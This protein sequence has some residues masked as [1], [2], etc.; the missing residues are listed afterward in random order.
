MKTNI[1]SKNGITLIA[2]VVTII[3]LLI[4]AGVSLNAIIGKNGIIENGEKS[5]FKGDVSSYK[6]ILNLKMLEE[7]MENENFVKNNVNAKTIA[8]IQKYIPNFN[9]KYENILEIFEGE[10]CA[11]SEAKG[12]ELSWLNELN[13]YNAPIAT[14]NIW[15]KIYQ[16][17]TGQ[18]IRKAFEQI[19]N[20]YYDESDFDFFYHLVDSNDRIPNFNDEVKIGETY[21][22]YQTVSQTDINTDTE[23]YSV[24]YINLKKG[25]DY[26][27]SSDYTELVAILPKDA[28]I[29]DITKWGAEVYWFFAFGLSTTRLT[30]KGNVNNTVGIYDDIKIG[31]LTKNVDNYQFMGVSKNGNPSNASDLCVLTNKVNNGETYYCDTLAKYDIT[32]YSYDQAVEDFK[33]N[34]PQ[35]LGNN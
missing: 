1:K 16:V 12:K 5:V 6:E 13:I 31:A 17:K 11:G 30:I 7:K 19:K 18:T 20:E 14:I 9:E 32:K 21:T 10:L 26:I 23:E 2:L 15:N 28:K 29:E 22:I 34:Y 33:T 25:K 4:L 27:P 3:V 8:E 35:F 24:V